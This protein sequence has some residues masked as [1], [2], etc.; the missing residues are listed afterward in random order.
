MKQNIYS[1]FQTA[2]EVTICSLYYINKS[3]V[4]RKEKKM[5]SFFLFSFLFFTS[6]GITYAQRDNVA[7][8]GQ[9]TGAG[10]SASYSIG[11]ID[12]INSTGSGGTI[13]Q[14]VQQPFEIFIITGI[15]ELSVNVTATAFPNPT[16]ESIVLLVN[17]IDLQKMS[18]QLYNTQ[19]KL[20][21]DEKISNSNTVILM[22]E[23]PS[24]AYFIKVQNE[25]KEIKTFKIIKN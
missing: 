20:L 6:I 11:Q 24:A 9:A 21:V 7:S 22:S 16:Q 23:L 3:P 25:N 10:G 8:G 5:K 13:L 4:R 14:G 17:N 2:K 18:Y 1:K 19:G 12:F 15:D